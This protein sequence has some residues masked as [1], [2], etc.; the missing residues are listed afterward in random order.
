MLTPGIRAPVHIDT[1]GFH[2][3]HYAVVAGPGVKPEDLLT[4]DYWCHVVSRFKAND[5]IEC[6]GKDFEL[7]LRVT[8]I[9]ESFASPRAE[10]RIVRKWPDS[11][12]V[13]LPEL[14]PFE[15]KVEFSGGTFRA[16]SATD[17]SVLVQGFEDAA[18]CEETMKRLNAARVSRP[19][20]R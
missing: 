18:A 7:D 19:D 20:A 14:K 8:R 12:E 11:L 16:I 17:G 9:D 13:R 1:V 6:I 3:S 10:F 5:L 15:F 4:D 2:Y